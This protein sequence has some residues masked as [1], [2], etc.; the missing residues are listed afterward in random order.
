M[1]ITQHAHIYS[2][3][4][5]NFNFGDFFL[6]FFIN[7][8]PSPTPWRPR[9]GPAPWRPQA[10]WHTKPDSDNCYL[11]CPYG[12][13]PQI[14]VHKVQGHGQSHEGGHQALLDAAAE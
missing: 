10:Y 3:H 4:T 1:T 13:V 14:Q 5:L 2:F 7:T 6:F 12:Y 9:V 8:A 11:C